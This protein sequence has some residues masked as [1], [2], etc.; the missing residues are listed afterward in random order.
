[1]NDEILEVINECNKRAFDLSHNGFHV[2]VVNQRCGYLHI[3]V[4][5][6]DAEPVQF[7]NPF[8]ITRN[9]VG[10]TEIPF[11]YLDFKVIARK[12]M[13]SIEDA[14]KQRLG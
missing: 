9:F 8:G 3:R 5:Y 12:T 6:Q 14:I 2:T 7:N 10:S 11:D 1:M 4:W 13:D